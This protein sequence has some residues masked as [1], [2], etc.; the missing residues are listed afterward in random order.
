[1]IQQCYA[2]FDTKASAFLT[3]FFL[4]TDGM[5]IRVFSDC[6]RDSQHQFG[7]HPEDFSLFRVGQFDADNGKLSALEGPHAVECLLVGKQVESQS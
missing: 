6:V 1:M 2:V 4:P 5:A 3:P 7:K